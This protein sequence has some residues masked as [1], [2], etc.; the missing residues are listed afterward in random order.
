MLKEERRELRAA[1]ADALSNIDPDVREALVVLR[2]LLVNQK[3]QGQ[4]RG[5]ASLGCGLAVR[6]GVARRRQGANRGSPAA[7][8]FHGAIRG[9]GDRAA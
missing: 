1:A 2:D 4:W 6:R 3:P 7:D 8:A 9:T 5:V